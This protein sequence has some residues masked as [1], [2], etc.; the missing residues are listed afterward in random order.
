VQIPASKPAVLAVVANRPAVIEPGAGVIQEIKSSGLG[1][2][3]PLGVSLSPNA[4]LGTIDVDGR[5]PIVEPDKPALILADVSGFTS[6]KA[7][8][9]PLVVRLD[10]GSYSKPVTGQ[11]SVALLDE[12]RG[13]VLVFTADG[14]PK[15]NSTIP[16]GAKDVRVAR[17]EDH[18]IYVD[19]GKGTH[20]LVVDSDGSVT[21]V[22]V[23][24]NDK[25]LKPTSPTPPPSPPAATVTSPGAPGQVRA[26]AGDAAATISWS[27]ASGTVGRYTVTCRD[28]GGGRGLA[29]RDVN[30]GQRSVRITG[31]TNGV[32]YTCAVTAANA[33][34]QGPAAT[35]PSFT[36]SSDVPGAPG[37]VTARTAPDGSVRVS[38]GAANGQ[39]HSISKYDIT[40][41]GSDGSSAIVASTGATQTDVTGLT[42]G[43]TYTFA[44]TATNDLQVAGPSSGGSG[45][46]TPYRPAD[47]P[48]VN[49]TATDGAVSVNWVAPRLNGGDLV[50]YVV[51]MPGQPDQ[52][53]G[54]GPVQYTGLAN[55]TAYTV[56][57]IAVTRPREGGANV[58]GAAGT[59]SATP[60]R[61]ATADVTG[62]DL[63][64]DRQVTVHLRLNLYNSG[65]A[66]CRLIF[67]G[68]LRWSG[69]CANDIVV[70]GLEYSTSYDVYASLVNA[71]GTGGT[72][73]HGSVTTNNA[74]PPPPTPTVSRG[75]A[76]ASDTSCSNPACAFVKVD[77][78]N[79]PANT[80]V[81][82][83][84][85]HSG[86][87]GGSGDFWTYSV[88]TNGSGASSS[89][90]CFYGYRGQS[91]W[92]RANGIESNHFVW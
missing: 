32:A 45:P 75:G 39:G 40:A 73:A 18:R 29:P 49:A 67:N 33:A 22:P 53:V 46:A 61:P 48:G 2:Q 81:S 17:G 16:G 90:I 77:L 91:V 63:T 62:V 55:G 82:I 60:G 88:T 71:Y 6:N 14:K 74:P 59:A 21:T 65:P 28:T 8:N 47:M 34:G 37:A 68:A 31:L 57:V 58:T 12:T 51:R 9:Q 36:P 76:R 83:T 78:S 42:L 35:S 50:H 10:G 15:G 54:G 24:A 56:T 66:T 19:N 25:N 52:L 92:V 26:Q 85:V 1:P 43:V 87:N 20:T 23:A 70:G 27:A 38:W 89:Q 3:V 41:N 30:G 79:F 84:C 44:V 5:L 69:G 72:G 7:G 80:R 13:S 4:K 11:G 64:G 86:P